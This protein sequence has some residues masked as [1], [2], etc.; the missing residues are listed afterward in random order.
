MTVLEGIR[1]L[2][3]ASMI[4]HVLMLDRRTALCIIKIIREEKREVLRVEV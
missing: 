3:S 4:C 1:T 2:K